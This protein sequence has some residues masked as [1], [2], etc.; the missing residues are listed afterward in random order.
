LTR[1]LRSFVVAALAGIVAV[2][3]VPTAASADPVA[4]K[5]A[6]AE[7]IARELDEQGRRISVL[8]EQVNNARLKADEVEAAAAALTA[9]VVRIEE[10]V[11]AAKARL[12]VQAVNA[13]MRGGQLPAVQLM[14]TGTAD[15]LALRQSYVKT[16]VGQERTALAE[17]HRAQD[18]RKVKQ[19]GLNEARAAARAALASVEAG[20]RDAAAAEAAQ[21]RTL[22]QVEGELASLVAEDRRRREEEAAQRARQELE[23]R[24]AEEEAARRRRE[25]DESARRSTTTTTRAGGG[26]TPTTKPTPTTTPPP[27]QP[28]RPPAA[29]AQAAVEEARKQIGKPYEWGA[30]GPDSF[31]CSGLTQWAWK[32]GGKSLPHSSQAQYSATSRVPV[33]QI[34][35]GDLTFYGSPI[36]HVG[37]YVGD[38]RM[39]EAS[40]TGTPVRYASIYRSDLVGVGRVG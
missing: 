10:Q 13:Y 36:H 40:Q 18:E 33:A 25:A 16:V 17:L 20:R 39:I 5:K 9:E 4:D 30:D 15:D 29:G 3:L 27:A 12:R 8:A 37:I 24:Q 21:R 38:G 14:I 19:A 23:R 31:D 26:S 35:P 32:A 6:E 1:P 11:E 22:A 28:T 7:R 34:Q 2:S